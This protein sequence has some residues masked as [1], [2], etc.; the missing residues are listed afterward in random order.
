[1][2]AVRA[3]RKVLPIV[4]VVVYATAIHSLVY[5]GARYRVPILPFVAILAS[6]GIQ[7]AALLV[8]RRAS[9]LS[10]LFEAREQRH[11]A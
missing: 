4:C 2:F 3:W 7:G 1:V 5:A 10:T 6:V 11:A 9:G 8:S